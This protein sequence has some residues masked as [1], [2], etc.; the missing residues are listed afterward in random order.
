[1][2]ELLATIIATMCINSSGTDYDWKCIDQINNCAV[3]L[4]TLATK[5]SIKRCIEEYDKN[6]N[7]F[8]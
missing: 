4:K 7:R 1:M 5:E 3:E 8:E 6:S 2:T